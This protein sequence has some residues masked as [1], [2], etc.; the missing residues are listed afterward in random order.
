VICI[1][2][3]KLRMGR[4][5]SS[6]SSRNMKGCLLCAFIVALFLSLIQ[7]RL[8]YHDASS[9]SLQ[10]SMN[11]SVNGNA[12][13]YVDTGAGFS[14]VG[15]ARSSV[16]GDGQFHAYTF[17][18]P[19]KTIYNFRFDPLATGG[20]VSINDIQVIDGFGKSMSSVNLGALRP[21][22]QIQSFDLKDNILKI[23][24]E[25][26]ADDPQI[27]LSLESPLIITSYFKSNIWLILIRFLG[28]FLVFFSLSILLIWM[29]RRKGILIGLFDHPA[30]T[31]F[32]WITANKLFFCS[33]I[34]IL[35]YRIF[36]V[37]TYPLDTCSDQLVYYNLMRS[38]KSTLVHA[39]GYPFFM[40]IFSP[41]LPSKTDVLV[42]QHLIDFGTQFIIM[43]LVKRRFGSMAAIVVGLSY[44]FDLTATNWVSRSTPEWLQGVFFA[45]AFVG[46]MEAYFAKRPVKKVILYLLSA[47]A[48]AW[49]VLIKFLT[50][51]LLPV[52]LVLFILEKREWKGK[53]L[54]FTAMA[55][56]IFAQ[57]NIFIYAYHYPST[58]TRALTSIVGW[59]LDTKLSFF[60]PE[61]NHLSEA[62]PWSKRYS[63]LVSEMPLSMPAG[64]AAVDVYDLFEHVDA[65][66]HEVRKPFQ[67]RY[68]ELLS[69]SDS[70]LQSIIEGKQ[71]L[72][73]LKSY[74]LSYIFLGLPETD[75]L[76]KNVF[77]EN[78]GK[79]PLEYLS[80]VLRSIKDS[81]FIETSY[82][83]AVIGNC[84]MGHPFLLNKDEI[85]QNLPWGYV[86]YNAHKVIRCMYERPVF[87]K[88]GLY[89]FSCWGQYVYIP[90]IFKWL[91]II[92]G[93]ILA[94]IGYKKDGRFGPAVLYLSMGITAIVSLIFISAL[95]H[96]FRDKE[97]EAC[98][99]LFS[100]VT[101]ISVSSIFSFLKGKI[102]S[103]K[104]R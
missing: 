17:S 66:P 99:Q 24:I 22:H 76:L 35:A 86:H 8:L 25:K 68:R 67:E 98:Q 31:T 72:R 81:F 10:I 94:F 75:S 5:S 90:V 37:F 2:S 48:F 83:I 58:G 91:V 56:V 11:A 15:T 33:I 64:E 46:A 88:A 77:L 26:H 32:K 65:V 93:T 16:K 30:E 49:T 39:T 36:F 95:L 101:G 59:T 23:D 3:K 57:V 47:W 50:V 38:D 74:F 70:E 63:I 85:I 6:E 82:Y 21:A 69:K 61:K 51:V 78:V 54:C 13:L 45:L 89:F 44:G 79:Y 41:W 29:L 71:T 27:I 19:V 40:H 87:L 14:E 80:H 62:G 18:L 12:V 42:F 28:G 9:F 84:G 53:W 43:A 7:A 97:F 100:I 4:F 73:G 60:L 96:C 103:A 104:M 1:E 52:Y 34:C 55:I 102:Y 92:L 20:S